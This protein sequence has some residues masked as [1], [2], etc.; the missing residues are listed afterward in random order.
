MYTSLHIY[1]M[2]EL[3]MQMVSI[4]LS[5]QPSSKVPSMQFLLASKDNGSRGRH[6]GTK[7][8]KEVVKASFLFPT[9]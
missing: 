7:V 3:L 1:I 9:W 4:G 8:D 5:G 6:Q 2:F